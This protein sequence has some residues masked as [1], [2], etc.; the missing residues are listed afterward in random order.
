[1]FNARFGYRW[2]SYLAAVDPGFLMGLNPTLLKN[3]GGSIWLEACEPA[4]ESV[5]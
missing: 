1:M 5:T 4:M 2:N 3:T